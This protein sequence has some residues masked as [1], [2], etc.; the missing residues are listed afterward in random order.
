MREELKGSSRMVFSSLTDRAK[1][2]RPSRDDLGPKAGGVKL[3]LGW[4]NDR[5]LPRAYGRM[6]FW[7]SLAS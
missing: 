5:F 7:I 3:R 6:I 2:H 4:K 1:V